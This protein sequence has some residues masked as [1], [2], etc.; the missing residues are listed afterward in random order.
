[1]SRRLLGILERQLGRAGWGSTWI[2]F[3]C[4]EL[5]SSMWSSQ[6]G[7]WS[8]SSEARRKCLAISCGHKFPGRVCRGLK[9]TTYPPPTVWG[10]ATGQHWGQ[11][12]VNQNT[13]LLSQPRLLRPWPP[14][15]GNK[16]DTCPLAL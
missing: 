2:W 14:D 16:V 7:S 15:Q 10:Q 5:D 1:M 6:K 12:L 3:E 4:V 13:N 11:T 9:D 8:F